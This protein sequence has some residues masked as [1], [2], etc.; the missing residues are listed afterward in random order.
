MVQSCKEGE[1]I[2]MEF[3]YLK[4][5]GA[6]AIVGT[7]VGFWSQIRGFFTQIGNLFIVE[8]Q[9]GWE[10]REATFSYL[11]RNYKVFPVGFYRLEAAH[12]LHKKHNKKCMVSF[13]QGAPCH[14]GDKF[15]TRVFYHGIN[16]IIYK[17]SSSLGASFIFIRGTLDIHKFMNKVLEDV[18]T[19]LGIGNDRFFIQNVFGTLEFNVPL[20]GGKNDEGPK[21]SGPDN[22]D[23][24]FERKMKAGMYSIIGYDVNDLQF[25][26]G[27]EHQYMD[28]LAFPSHVL[29]A[30][31]E[32][33]QWKILKDWYRGRGIPW[34]R[35]WLLYGQPGNG[36]SA[37][38]RAVGET[39][40]MPVYIY[41]LITMTNTDLV[42]EWQKMLKNTPCIALF[43]DIDSVFDRRTN[44]N[45]NTFQSVLSFDTFLNCLDGVDKN[46]GIFTIITTNNLDKLDSALGI[47]RTDINVNGTEISTRP[48]R[49][50]RAIELKKP[51]GDCRMKIVSRILRDNPDLWVSYVDLGKDDTAAQFNERCVQKALELYWNKIEIKMEQKSGL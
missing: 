45:K 17:H 43:E 36:K 14:V 35:G 29:K 32:I 13:E 10:L 19:R 25:R 49:I 48:G 31:H 41:H 11:T 37:L 16:I 33:E 46:E 26:T 39:L 15:S 3:D 18:N 38:V 23:F 47:P 30:V 28:Y 12:L 51:D 1:V 44:L 50:D 2:F 9:I 5:I 27:Y 8:Y 34:K 20:Q 24:S 40:D 4:I 6:T 7:I 21:P 42:G 22:G